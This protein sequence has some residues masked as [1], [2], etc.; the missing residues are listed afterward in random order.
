MPRLAVYNTL[1]TAV[2]SGSQ[3]EVSTLLSRENIHD[4]HGYFCEKPSA[5]I[6][7]ACVR[8]DE[9]LRTPLQQR[10]T[11]MIRLLLKH[12]AY[13]PA[14]ICV[15]EHRYSHRDKPLTPLKLAVESGSIDDVRKLLSAG[16]DVNAHPR[17]CVN[18]KFRI[19]NT[20]A[21]CD[22]PLMTA[23]RRRDVAMIQLLIAHGADVSV[24]IHKDADIAHV[25]SKTALL[26][27]TEIGDEQVITELV[28]C[29]A[30]V[31]QLLSPRGT[32]VLHYCCHDDEL[33]KLL[34]SLGADPN[35][36]DEMGDTVSIKVLLRGNVHCDSTDCLDSVLQ[37]LRLLLPITRL[38]DGDLRCKFC[39]LLRLKTECTMLVLQHGA[40][41]YYSDMLRM[42]IDARGPHVLSNF[43]EHSEEFF[44]FL[45]AADTSFTG[46]RQRIANM[47]NNALDK[48]IRKVLNLD[49]LEDK[50]SQPLTLQTSCVISVRRH[51]RS[52]SDVGMWT[53]IDALPLP[54]AIQNML[55]LI[56]W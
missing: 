29:G 44:E 11:D 8:C 26:V 23:V 48:T 1:K 2:S 7:S 49:V 45:R 54:A 20:C 32:T 3:R 56:V 39:V 27:A 30:D 47:G 22:S 46:V 14:E 40:R 5:V 13:P 15:S 4:I 35:A 24:K 6:A 42:V 38:L 41:I 33:V 52:V 25:S 17:M 18:T 36:R 9:L 34:L 50:L 16:A 21:D 43:E 10:D 55:K 31:N 12:R 37:S 53:R 19:Y 28:T 51:L